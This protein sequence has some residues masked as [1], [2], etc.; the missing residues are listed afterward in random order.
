MSGVLGALDRPPAPGEGP[1][2]L[3]IGNHRSETVTRLVELLEQSLGRA[4]VVT[5]VPKPAADVEAT[6]ADVDAIAALP[7]FVPS[8]PL[9]VGIPRFARWF[10]EFRRQAE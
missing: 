7:G 9:V 10:M 4:A 8:T 6:W 2:L 1:R 5:H 3:N